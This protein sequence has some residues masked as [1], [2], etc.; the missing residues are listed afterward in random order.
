MI[1]H[2]PQVFGVRVVLAWTHGPPPE[3]AMFVVEQIGIGSHLQQ[4]LGQTGS[5]GGCV[6]QR[7]GGGVAPGVGWEVEGGMAQVFNGYPDLIPAAR[8]Y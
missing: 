1:G 5:R 7:I 4:E 3:R 6:L 8:T 2:H